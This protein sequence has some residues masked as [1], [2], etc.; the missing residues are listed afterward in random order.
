MDLVASYRI[1]G[2]GRSSLDEF[3][4]AIRTWCGSPRRGNVPRDRGAPASASVS[5]GRIDRRAPRPLEA[6]GS[7]RSAYSGVPPRFVLTYFG[8]PAR[9]AVCRGDNCPNSSEPV[10]QGEREPTRSHLA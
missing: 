5:M 10:K 3:A 4:Q 2:P 8:D 9:G 6:A 7:A 1:G